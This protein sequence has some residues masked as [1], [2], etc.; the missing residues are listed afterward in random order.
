MTLASM[1]GFARV[2]G[3]SANYRWAWEVKTVNAKGLDLRLRVAP[4][5]DVIEA[6]ARA[7][8]V[9]HLTRGT[10]YATLSVQRDAAEPEVYVNR[11]LLRVIARAL[12]DVELS[13]RLKPASLDGLLSIRGVVEVRERADTE[14]EVSTAQAAMLASLDEALGALVAMRKEEGQALA[15]VLGA[16]VEKIVALQRAAEACPGRKPEAIEARL[17]ES[18]ALL[19]R[20]GRFDETRLYQEAVLLAAKADVR[21][22]LDRLAAHLDAIAV[23]LRKGGPIGRR[24]DFLA[25][26]LGREANTLCAKSNDA[27]L[28][29]IGLE[30]RVEIEQFREQIQNIE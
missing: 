9:Q 20:A 15:L 14:A 4:G 10:C 8:L 22:E 29:A 5:F 1:T 12:D 7:R 27:G 21:E 6:E 19:N 16:R 23:L 25:Q 3:A 2:A 30:L 26:E 24:L 13:E 28:T 17:A 18:V 11:D